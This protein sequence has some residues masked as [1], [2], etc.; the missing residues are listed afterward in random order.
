[1]MISPFSVIIISKET[2][3]VDC[4]R[5]IRAVRVAGVFQLHPSLGNKRC[6]N[7]NGD[8]IEGQVRFP[9]RRRV[10]DV[11]GLCTSPRPAHHVDVSSLQTGIALL[12]RDDAGPGGGGLHFLLDLLHDG[13]PGLTMLM[14]PG[15]GNFTKLV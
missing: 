6:V 3:A 13:I 10:C 1:M 5:W 4:F 9:G 11:P 2:V 14:E 7:R 15:T 8:A 12:R